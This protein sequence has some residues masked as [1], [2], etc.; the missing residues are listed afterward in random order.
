MTNFLI[1]LM[2]GLV[3]NHS[4]KNG[5]FVIIKSLLPSARNPLRHQVQ[6]QDNL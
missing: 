5:K 6:K 4:I 2:V 1:P 3:Q